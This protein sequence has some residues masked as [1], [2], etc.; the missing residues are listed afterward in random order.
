M[1]FR[2]TGNFYKQTALSYLNATVTIVHRALQA[3]LFVPL[4][5]DDA[6]G[7]GTVDADG[8][9]GVDLRK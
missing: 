9:D 6:V 2:R 4:T 7:I 5:F 1:A 8:A 3:P